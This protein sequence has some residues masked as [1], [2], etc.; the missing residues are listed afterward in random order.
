LEFGD[1]R[2]GTTYDINTSS[3]KTASNSRGGI[4][5]SLIYA[6]RPNTDRNIHCP[7]F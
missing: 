3:L 1:F 4:E 5:I 6:H 2:L 7:K